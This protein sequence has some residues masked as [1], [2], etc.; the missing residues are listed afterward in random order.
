MLKAL[1]IIIPILV[2][3]ASI[4][5]NYHDKVDRKRLQKKLAKELP[6]EPI[7]KV[8]LDKMENF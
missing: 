1:R 3:L 8:T 2:R 7:Q 5:A 4:L 6:D